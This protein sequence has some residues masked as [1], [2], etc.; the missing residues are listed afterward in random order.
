MKL[1]RV[2]KKLKKDVSVFF[3]FRPLSQNSNCLE[4]IFDTSSPEPEL[5]PFPFWR[6]PL[7]QHASN[8]VAHR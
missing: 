6:S 3:N 4:G 8:V 2:D 7:L 1:H 5:P